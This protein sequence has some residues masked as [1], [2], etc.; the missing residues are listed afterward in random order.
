MTE[1]CTTMAK[2]SGIRKALVAASNPESSAVSE[3]KI[4]CGPHT[5]RM[6]SGTTSCRP[7]LSRRPS[8]DCCLIFYGNFHSIQTEPEAAMHASLSNHYSRSQLERPIRDIDQIFEIRANS[9]LEQP[10]QRCFGA[11]LSRMGVQTSG[12][13]C[14]H[15]LRRMCG[16]LRLNWNRNLT[17]VAPSLRSYATVPRYPRAP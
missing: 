12:V 14:R 6:R 11:C 8:K 1:L 15:S 2:L 16:W 17:L 13:Q 3:T 4:A 7:L 9:V 10:K 5:R